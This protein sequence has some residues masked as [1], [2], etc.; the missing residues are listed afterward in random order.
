LLNEGLACKLILIS[1]PA[2]FGKTTLIST[3][4]DQDKIP[5]A[6]LSLDESENDPVRFLTYIIAALQTVTPGIGESILGTL[7]SPRADFSKE[8]LISLINE[9]TASFSDDF[10]LVLED[11]HT[12]SSRVVLNIT[13]FLLDHLPPKMHIVIASRADPDLPLPLLRGS[14]DMVEIRQDALRF[15]HEEVKSF[16]NKTLSVKLTNEDIAAL[17]ARTEGWIAGLQMAALSI[18]GKEDAS[19]YVQDLTGTDRYI[20]DY[21][22]EEVLEQQPQTVQ[23]FL[24]QTSIVGK[25][26]GPLCNAITGAENAQ[27]MLES[28][29]RENLFIL[30]M[31]HQRRWYRYHQLFSDL[32]KKRLTQLHPEIIPD[33]HNRAS[34]WYAG[35]DLT[36]EA[37]QHSLAAQKY[38]RAAA[39]ME[40]A[41]EDIMMRSEFSTLQEW[42]KALPDE[43]LR[44]RP[45]LCLFYAY[46]L[47]VYS[48]PLKTVETYI[49]Y[50]AKGSDQYQGHVAS[51][52]AF[53]A[54]LQRNVPKANALADSALRNLPE[55]DRFFRM[56]TLW[57]NTAANMYSG[58]LADRHLA[59]DDVAQLSQV[60]GNTMVTTI[61]RCNQAWLHILKGELHQAQQLFEK[62]MNLAK[63]QDG[64]YLP[65]AGEAFLGL[66]YLLCEWNRFDESLEY[67]EKGLA[68]TDKWGVSLTSIDGLLAKA[69]ILKARGN[70]E[71]AHEVILAAQRLALQSEVTAMDDYLVDAHMARNHIEQGNIDAAVRWAQG[72]GLTKISGDSGD[73][74]IDQ[75]LVELDQIIAGNFLNEPRHRSVEYFSLVRI[76]LAVGQT[77]DALAFLEKLLEQ[78]QGQKFHGRVIYIQVL[79][80]LAHQLRAEE[81]QALDALKKALSLAE[82]EG[83][84]RVFLDE[85][86][87]LQN[88]LEQAAREEITPAYV[89]QLLQLFRREAYSSGQ[90]LVDPL[91][92]RELEILRMLPTKFT[93]SEIA[94]QLFIAE[95][96]VRTHIKHIYSKLNVNRRFEAVERARELGLI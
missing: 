50:A 70:L 57:G 53:M 33:L 66:G 82:S 36:A 43:T 93:A 54:V 89:N 35:N 64:S 48:Y 45:I 40:K 44:Q 30:P 34:C 15:T 78:S 13:K 52:R 5:A 41:A 27:E 47:L 68:L 19:R 55:R 31:D 12:L 91:S 94:E 23:D 28:F 80:A 21:L 56:I 7:Q 18:S 60:A 63:G 77:E 37:I 8:I 25:L 74:S 59:L 76:L 88:L 65:I 42:I 10:I 2:G 22:V 69:R 16:L 20:L 11:Y 17:E 1:A 67:L 3:W 92:A 39:L 75:L 32:L 71:S 90:P 49:E 46:I 87:P 6:W 95:S 79:I 84:V 51:L 14:G 73:L 85:G 72:R 96:T 86:V 4:I 29:E 81:R 62:T 58:N 26:S 61:V 9:I 24:L 83:Y 38:G